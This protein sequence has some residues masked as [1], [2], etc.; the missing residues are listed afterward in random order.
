MCIYDVYLAAQ[1]QQQQQSQWIGG[2]KLLDISMAYASQLDT[3]GRPTEVSTEKKATVAAPAAAAPAAAPA[4]SWGSMSYA[5]AP[6]AAAPPAV[7]TPVVNK[8]CEFEVIV[9]N[10][11]SSYRQ[12]PY[13]RPPHVGY[14]RWL[15][16][17]VQS[18]KY[19]NVILKFVLIIT[20]F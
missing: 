20:F 19:Y 17:R 3:T 8:L 6:A 13:V 9:Y 11:S 14:R 2:Q 5:A 16:V 15:Q 4:A 12:K 18:R 7:A 10:Q 1:P